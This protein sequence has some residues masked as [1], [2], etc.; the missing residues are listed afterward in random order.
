MKKTV[1]RLLTVL[2]AAALLCACGKQG[3][4]TSAPDTQREKGTVE[5]TEKNWQQ[6]FEIV[7]GLRVEETKNE[8]GEVTGRRVC[9]AVLLT[10]KDGLVPDAAASDVT[11]EYSADGSINEISY[12]L[13]EGTYT[14]GKKVGALPGDQWVRGL[15]EKP[16]RCPGFTADERTFLY[17]VELYGSLEQTAAHVVETAGGEERLQ[18]Y[19]ANIAIT[20]ISGRLVLK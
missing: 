15:V 1:T 13:R 14:V 2:L 9:V 5:I 17:A 4:G 3:G 16:G 6:Y 7:E 18:G 10:V 19:P 12:N 8:A 20:R 11:V